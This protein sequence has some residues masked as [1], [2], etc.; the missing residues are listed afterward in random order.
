L[1]K[2]LAPSAAWTHKVPR[3]HAVTICDE[4]AV[5]PQILCRCEHCR[6]EF[7]RRYEA[8]LPKGLG[9]LKDPLL[10]HKAAR[11]YS[12]Y[13]A[14]VW[15]ESAD[16]MHG[17]N[18]KFRIRNNYTPG[19]FGTV[20]ISVA[21]GDLL[22]WCEPVDVLSTTGG[23]PY[24]KSF[25]NRERL[26]QTFR[27][28]RCTLAF[29]RGAAVEQ[30]KPFG[31]WTE[32]CV[33][34]GG[35]VRAARRN[36]YMTIGAG[37][38]FITAW[39]NGLAGPHAS[40]HP[41]L[42]DDL[43]KAHREVASIGPLLLRLKRK[44]SVAQLFP[45]SDWILGRKYSGPYGRTMEYYD[46]LSKALGNV[47]ILWERQIAKGRLDDYQVLFLP[48]VT[49][50]RRDAAQAVVAFLAKGGIVIA[51]R[52]PM[53]DELGEKMDTFSAVL[54]VTVEDSRPRSPTDVRLSAAG[55]RFLGI[56]PRGYRVPP[57]APVL[58]KFA[59]TGGPAIIEGRHGRGKTLFFAFDT[60]RTH[61]EM[62]AEGS[63]LRGLIRQFVERSGVGIE[64]WSHNPLVE[65]NSFET[66]QCAFL[67]LVNGSEQ[68]QRCLVTM[69]S[70]PCRPAFVCDLITRSPVTCRSE[71]R[72]ASI[73]VELDALCG[74]VIGVYGARPASAGLTIGR[75]ALLDTAF[76]YKIDLKAPNGEPA[77]GS[78]VI[79]VDITD[80]T[81]AKRPE[82]GRLTCTTSGGYAGSLRTALNDP[83]GEWLIT[84][85]EALTQVTASARFRSSAE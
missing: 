4:P 37:A 58:A 3:L 76:P 74:K 13:F 80:P 22:S 84:V 79:R 73:S 78:Y 70:L 14:K 68:Q 5:R 18:P 46:L 28:R 53:L 72:G 29:L 20:R 82:Y 23:Y 50:L 42:W 75:P 71:Q 30:G 43:G 6:A 52:L 49:R 16:F 85:T 1:E 47:D 83:R 54:G 19:I 67:I 63:Q 48:N 17:R 10:T 26:E 11:F 39:Y 36:L 33:P 27:N 38:K 81:G 25:P 64:A 65:C 61:A 62:Q 69:R 40:A 15:Q 77:S 8:E 66:P 41:A 59:D 51:D 12:D 34:Q 2:L 60:E 55:R 57:G 7:R 9:G 56:A 31:A 45:R 24:I 32:T 44:A 21:M 35:P